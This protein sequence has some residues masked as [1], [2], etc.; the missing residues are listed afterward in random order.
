MCMY[1]QQH[2]KHFDA[3]EFTAEEREI[4]VKCHA[5][6]GTWL[7]EYCLVCGGTG[8]EPAKEWNPSDARIAS[9]KQKL[10]VE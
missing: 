2:A 5:C 6:H 7:R 1:M 3:A 8:I 10:G 4:P 9:I